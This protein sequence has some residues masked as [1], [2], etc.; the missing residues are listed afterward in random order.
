M[1]RPL[2]GAL[3]VEGHGENTAAPELLNRLWTHLGL[4]SVVNWEKPLLRNN[5]LKNADYLAET[6]QRFWREFKKYNVL[7]VIYDA[8]FEITPSGQ[9]KRKACP[10]LDGPAAAAIL[11]AAKLPIPAAVVLPWPEYEH[12]IVASLPAM[13]GRSVCDPRSGAQL[14]AIKADCSTALS[15]IGHRDGKGAV[16]R[17]L[18]SNEY[19]PTTHQAALTAMLDF[20]HLQKA[21]I[22]THVPAFGTLCRACHHLHANLGTEGFVYP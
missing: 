17:F 16:G 9:S 11:R 4:N 7:M 19:E 18:E 22:D 1:S 10:K 3:L 6:M 12:W 5:E 21:E 13:Q 14:T 2:R 20:A 8:D 15:H